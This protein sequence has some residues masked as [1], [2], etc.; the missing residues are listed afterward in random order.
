MTADAIIE[1]MVYY[2]GK[3]ARSGW[4]RCGS[5]YLHACSSESLP[6]LAERYNRGWKCP[7]CGKYRVDTGVQKKSRTRVYPSPG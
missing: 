2:S 4:M 5:A 7:T 3:R 1:V 6:V